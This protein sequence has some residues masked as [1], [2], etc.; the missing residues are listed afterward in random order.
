Q[1]S[2]ITTAGIET[3]TR[4]LVTTLA[5]SDQQFLQLEGRVDALGGRVD[6]LEFRLDEMNESTRGGIAASMALGGTMVVPDS[7]LSVNFNLATYRGEQ[8]F[9]GTVAARVAPRVYVSAG[10]AGSTAKKSTGG[11]VG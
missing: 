11:R 7:A 1:A 9:S 5:V 8:G 6:A 3:I 4:Q 2:A 10:I